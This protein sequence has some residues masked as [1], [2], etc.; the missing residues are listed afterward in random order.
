MRYILFVFRRFKLVRENYTLV[1]VRRCAPGR[2]TKN[3]AVRSA[4]KYFGSVVSEHFPK[5]RLAF[6]RVKP[7]S[8]ISRVVDCL[9]ALQ[10]T[11]GRILL[12]QVLYD[13]IN[14]QCV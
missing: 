14:K 6:A 8:A 11:D 2:G 4:R 7:R 12:Y 13:A 1:I 3:A 5:R 9:R 10:L